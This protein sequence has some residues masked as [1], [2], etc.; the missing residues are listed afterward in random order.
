MLGPALPKWIL[1]VTSAHVCAG[2]TV[3]LVWQATGDIQNVL[4]YFRYP[5]RMLLVGSSALELW[6]SLTAARAFTLRDPLQPAWLMIAASATSRLVGTL[7]AN[8]YPADL[9]EVG[10]AIGG[11]VQ[12]AFLAV[13][14]L[15]VLRVYRRLGWLARPKLVD[16]ALFAMVLGFTLYQA[17]EV[18]PWRSGPAS[19]AS[20]IAAINWASDPLLSLLLVEAIV[21]RRTVLQMRGGLV[22]RC[23]G[24]YAAAIV[25][26][27][28]GD[29][30]IW[31]TAY[32]HLPWPLSSLNWYVWL[33]SA[34]AYAV[35]PAY[36]VAAVQRV[37]RTVRALAVAAP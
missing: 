9:R 17:I 34:G 21:L 7:F 29:I 20:G 15:F 32:G 2:L 22:A 1:L 30:G 19:P 24:F 28:I 10:L 5:G 6:L 31:A 27:L 11:P 18:V 8:F 14:L 3:W 37:R 23:W 25:I 4:W 16:Y 35:A 26:T 36:Q 13:G 12:M 33:V